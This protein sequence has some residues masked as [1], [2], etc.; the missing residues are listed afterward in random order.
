MEGVPDKPVQEQQAARPMLLSVLCVLTFI[1]SGLNILSGLA[2]GTFFDEFSKIAAGFAETYNLPGME[3][4]TEGSPGFF[5][6]SAVFYACSVTGAVL[7]W[8]LARTGFH[9]YTIS[10]ILLLIAPMYFF[11]LRGPSTPDLIF[12]GLFIILYGL[13]LRNMK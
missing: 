9:V 10:Q 4:I 2:I 1:G 11:K 8:K 12:T 5:F 7:M 6:V 13:N 3:I